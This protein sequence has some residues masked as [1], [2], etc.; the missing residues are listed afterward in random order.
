M[1][2]IK[3]GVRGGFARPSTEHPNYS[4]KPLQIARAG[5]ENLNFSAEVPRLPLPHAV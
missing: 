3:P 4:K 2:K 1:E 5:F